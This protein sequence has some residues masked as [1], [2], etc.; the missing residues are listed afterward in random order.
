MGINNTK[1]MKKPTDLFDD[2]FEVIY[3][4]EDFS[5]LLREEMTEKKYDDYKDV[6]SN[7]SEMDDTDYIEKNRTGYYKK[8]AHKHNPNTDTRDVDAVSSSDKRKSKKHIKM[9]N[10]VSPVAK[11][12]KAGGKAV[13]KVVNMLLRAATLILIAAVIYTLAINFWKNHSAYGDISLAI[14]DKNYILCAYAG[15][16]AFL[17]L[18]ELIAF[19]M[20][21][22]GS[23]KS[24]RKGRYQDTGRGLFSFLFIYAGA[25]LAYMLNGLIP[26]SPAPLQGV[27]GALLVYG[28]LSS[29]LLPLCTA[30]I[31][32]CLV[33]RFL[34]R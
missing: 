11:T 21:L 18:F 30:G 20:V 8:S 14:A 17:L 10:L 33:R 9:P 7:L 32:S 1:S 24:G 13:Y 34:I 15:V 12:A 4:E 3:Q 31:I 6:L 26:A 29:A 25:Y 22:L 28:S 23:K 5:D 19:L 16:A 2:D 27:Q